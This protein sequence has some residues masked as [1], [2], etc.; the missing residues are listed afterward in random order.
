MR[1]INCGD[2]RRPVSSAT[3]LVDVPRPEQTGQLL[4]C[5]WFR[6]GGAIVRTVAV[7]ARFDHPAETTLDEMRV[8]LLSP[9]DEAAERFFQTNS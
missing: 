4:V 8:E 2:G 7:V 1:S 3:A 5:P 9:M 6:V